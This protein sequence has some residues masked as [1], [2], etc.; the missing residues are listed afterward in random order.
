MFKLGNLIRL[1]IVNS[2]HAFLA[3]EE[4]LKK[5]NFDIVDV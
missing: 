5:M 3:T 4:L 2:K 1:F